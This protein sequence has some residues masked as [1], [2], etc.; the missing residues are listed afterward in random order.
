MNLSALTRHIL[1]LCL[2]LVL[3]PMAAAA[4]P[5]TL[6]KEK[7]VVGYLR[8]HLHGVNPLDAEA[9]FKTLARTL[10][11]KHG[12][13][14][15]VTVKS[16]ADNHALAQ[17]LKDSTLHLIIFNSWDYINSSSKDALEPMFVPASAGQPLQRYLLLSKNNDLR[18]ISDLQGKSINILRGP[19]S[20]LAAK[21]LDV[22]LKEQMQEEASTFFG[23]IDYF[24][25]PLATVLPVYFGKKDVALVNAEQIALMT[26][27]NPQLSQLLTV[28][29]SVP[30]L[31]R[32]L[33]FGR[34]GWTSNKFKEDI[35]R[36]MTYLH[37]TIAGQQILTL[38]QTTQ[39][40]PFQQHH[41][42]N[43]R[44]LQEKMTKLRVSKAPKN[45]TSS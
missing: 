40:V 7:L 4:T 21:W 35:I 15:D 24:Q 6:I 16:F 12:Y 27:L 32:V 3:P 34:S 28:A 45:N 13:E 9:A 10:G 17:Y 37:K 11:V 19:D 36:A 33:C 41:L 26:E 23:S 30:F 31:N 29:P 42:E 5:E 22:L 8:G 20:T 18:S 43:V 44:I 38:F 1:L 39:M 2:L 25:E 14:I